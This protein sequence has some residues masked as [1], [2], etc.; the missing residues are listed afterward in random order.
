MEVQA[1]ISPA[2][3]LVHN[4]IRVHDSDDML[5]YRQVNI[6]FDNEPSDTGTLAKGPPTEGSHTR[7]HD[8]REAIALHMWEDYNTIRWQ[9]GQS[10]VESH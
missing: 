5:D 8:H 9:R 1:R 4:V 10:A 2:L 7:S 3:C 6:D